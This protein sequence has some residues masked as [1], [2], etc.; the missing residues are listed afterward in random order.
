MYL[1]PN[2]YFITPFFALWSDLL[3]T[4]DAVDGDTDYP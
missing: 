2:P 3:L 1:H 4:C